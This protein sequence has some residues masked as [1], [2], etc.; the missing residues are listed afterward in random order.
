MIGATSYPRL[1]CTDLITKACHGITT[2]VC[3]KEKQVTFDSVDC[4]KPL[5]AMQHV[6]N[7]HGEG[8]LAALS[9]LMRTQAHAASACVL[10]TNL[11]GL[12]LAAGQFARTPQLPWTRYTQAAGAC[13]LSDC[14][15]P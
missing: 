12:V 10:A 1:P 14:A 3:S 8:T 7:T 4:S 5:W 15:M 2:R 9:K 13:R 6:Q 11:A